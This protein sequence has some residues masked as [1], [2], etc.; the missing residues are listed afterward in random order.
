M[1]RRLSLVCF[2]LAAFVLCSLTGR[3]E[4]WRQF[5]GN[6]ISG[7]A[8]SPLPGIISGDSIKW[9][10]DLP[11][12]GLS[13]PIV[14]G[15]R[16]YLT[17]SSGFDQ[18][19]LHLLC[20]DKNSGK[21]IWERQFWAVGRTVSHPK[22]CNATPTPCSDGQRIFATFSSND[23]ICTDLDGNLQWFRALNYDY[24][25]AT[26]SL[27]MSSSPVVVDDTLIVQVESDADSFAFGLDVAS[28]T[29]RWKKERPRKANWTSPTIVEKPQPLVLLQSGDGIEAVEPKSGKTVWTFDNGASTI[30]S[31]VVSGEVLYI[32]S[33]GITAVDL[34][35]GQGETLWNVKR[36]GPGT[37]SPILVNGILVSVAGTLS[38]A[39]PKTG[40]RLWEARFKGPYS[41]SPIASGKHLYLFSESGMAY[42]IEVTRDEAKLVSDF[43]FGE[44]IL[45]T[46]A[47]S[48]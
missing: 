36:L 3:A 12:R 2:C 45:G 15:D 37:P 33:N 17:A 48:D 8:Q 19:R 18:D 7:V 42:V 20:F 6:D 44:T 41:S 40:D 38:G 29:E 27:G 14:I 16:L 9:N 24:P 35:G 4:D 39:D 34:K 28:G 21:K 32:P 43:D 31:S 47:A 25:N 11:G 46:P 23:V 5:R 13:A 26:N 22:M 30:P 10:V 1:I